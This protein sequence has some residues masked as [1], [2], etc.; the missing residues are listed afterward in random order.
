MTTISV[1]KKFV[2]TR[3]DHTTQVFEPGVHVVEDDIATHWFV[4]AQAS[5]I[6]VETDADKAAAASLAAARQAER[7]AE[8]LALQA[9]TSAINAKTVVDG[10]VLAGKK[11]VKPPQQ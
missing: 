5:V 11:T 4:G 3:D 7:A 1:L 9:D 6:A 8:A 2:L 10:L